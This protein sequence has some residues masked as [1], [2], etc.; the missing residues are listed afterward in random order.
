[1][2]IGDI[3]GL[4]GMSF[5]LVA[6]IFNQLHK[7]KDTYLRY[8]IFNAI[9]SGLLIYYSI[10]LESLPFF[11]LNAIWFIVSIRDVYFD[12]RNIEKHKV[13]HRYKKR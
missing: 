10:I 7:W 5:I 4:I 8:D 6:F 3:I 11:I 1:M 13:H 2:F 9:G 12:I